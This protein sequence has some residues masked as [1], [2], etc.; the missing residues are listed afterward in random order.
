MKQHLS[1]AVVLVVLRQGAEG[2][3]TT[4]PHTM[5]IVLKG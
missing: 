1:V 4:L 5:K 3:A 2:V